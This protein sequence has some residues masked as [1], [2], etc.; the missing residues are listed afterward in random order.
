MTTPDLDQSQA[1]LQGF[2]AQI[3]DYLTAEQPEHNFL[4]NTPRQLDD[5]TFEHALRDAIIH[6]GLGIRHGKPVLQKFSVDDQNL[7]LDIYDD[8]RN[9]ILAHP[10]YREG[11]EYSDLAEKQLFSELKKHSGTP[12]LTKEFSARGAKD[13][14]FAGRLLAYAESFGKVSGFIYQWFDLTKINSANDVGAYLDLFEL[15][16]KDSTRVLDGRKLF[17]PMALYVTDRQKE[18][19]DA[20]IL[21]LLKRPGLFK[22]VNG[23]LKI[24]GPVA[25]VS[26]A[27]TDLRTACENGLIG[28]L[29]HYIDVNLQD[30]SN[31]IKG[32]SFTDG[33]KNSFGFWSNQATDIDALI[34]NVG[35]LNVSPHDIDQLLGAYSKLVEPVLSYE[36]VDE[37]ASFENFVACEEVPMI[38]LK[39]MVADGRKHGLYSNDEILAARGDE[40]R[41]YAI[42]ADFFTVQSF[43]EHS[44]KDI[45]EDFL[46]HDLGL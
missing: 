13:P 29:N 21:G 42:A 2:T 14:A 22:A 1:T 8:W 7:I 34:R 9:T 27:I 46:A 40:L 31:Y 33:Q 18:V 43:I 37:F 4:V 23:I 44:K 28:H 26:M 32:S 30:I 45:A 38:I 15:L 36:A 16:A 17:P 19:R 5:K 35:R 39:K 11:L 24:A 6:C 20:V 25:M 41:K 12:A 10:K 3:V